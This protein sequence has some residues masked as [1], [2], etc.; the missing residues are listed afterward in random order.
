MDGV[1]A[2]SRGRT[3]QAWIQEWHPAPYRLLYDARP[4]AKLEVL[5]HSAFAFLDNTDDPTNCHVYFIAG[6]CDITVRERRGSYEEVYYIESRQET[7]DRMT[8]LIDSISRDITFYGAKPCFSTIIPGSLAD[9]NHLR[10][11][12]GKTSHLRYSHQYQDMQNSMNMAIMDINQHISATNY[13]NNMQTPHLA[14]TIITQ[15]HNV[16]PRFH[17]S[18]LADGV[19]PT[20]ELSD[21]WAIWLQKSI[22]N[23]RYAATPDLSSWDNLRSASDQE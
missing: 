5:Q 1:F 16:K 17:L 20:Q 6:Y 18:R 8:K 19:H 4:S 15:R 11:S 14:S 10:K 13:S 12:Q 7:V 23:N 3:M 22:A 2:S 9:W 21:R